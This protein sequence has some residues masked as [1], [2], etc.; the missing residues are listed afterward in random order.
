MNEM[1]ERAAKAIAIEQFG[2]LEN[3]AWTFDPIAEAVPLARAVIAALR[4]PTEAM[5]LAGKSSNFLEW[6]LEP[7]E[8][9]DEIKIEKAW[10]SMIDSILSPSQQ[11]TST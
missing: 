10:R 2:D 5:V 8:G 4:E 9:I 1:I 3:G 7:G 6:S 11:G